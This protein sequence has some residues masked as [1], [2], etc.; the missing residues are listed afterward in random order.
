MLK[1]GWHL[2]SLFGIYLRLRT[3]SLLIFN[4]SSKKANILKLIILMDRHIRAKE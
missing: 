1:G 2:Q 4:L 3:S